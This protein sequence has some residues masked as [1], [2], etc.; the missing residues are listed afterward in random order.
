MSGSNTSLDVGLIQNA[1]RNQFTK[2]SKMKGNDL[3]K[4]FQTKKSV[5]LDC[6]KINCLITS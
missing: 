5:A 2:F 3:P 6:K 1:V 4:I